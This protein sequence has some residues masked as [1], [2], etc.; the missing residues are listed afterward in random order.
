M[1]HGKI[2][3]GEA[4]LNITAC[5]IMKE[6]VKPKNIC[7]LKISLL[8]I[9]LIVSSNTLVFSQPNDYA[10]LLQ[11]APLNGGTVTPGI[12]VHRLQIN[13]II[14][15][16]AVPNPG[17]QFVYWLGDVVD[18]TSSKT[19]TIADSPKI[20]VAVFERVGYDF[21]DAAKATHINLGPPRTIPSFN[22]TGGGGG[23]GGAGRRPRGGRTF[24]ELPLVIEEEAIPDENDPVP[25]PVPEPATV[26]LLGLGSMLIMKNK[27]K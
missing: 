1:G 17:Y 8:S 19:E 23:G 26:I 7:W 15:L 11:Q 20:I 14:V 6:V 24:E 12:G 10:L 27:N 25:V 9:A 16:K 13:D 4:V 21:S 18:A 2:Y 22:R 3:L 5:I